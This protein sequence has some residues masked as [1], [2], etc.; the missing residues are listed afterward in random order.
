MQRLF[1]LG[2]RLLTGLVLLGP[3]TLAWADSG[4]GVD[5]WRGNKLDP[6]AG[7]AT[8][9]LDPDGTSWLEPG[10]HR[11]PTGNLYNEPPAEP[12]VET[13]SV[14]QIYGTF[15]VGYLHTTGER[16]ALFDRYSRWP[17]NG[18]SFGFDVKPSEL[19]TAA[20]PNCAAASSAPKTSTT[21]P[22]TARRA[23]TRRRSSF[24]TCRTCCPPTPSPFST[25]SAAMI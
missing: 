20:T 16:T 14:W 12:P 6:T 15:D 25:A 22:F 7:Q 4:V 23:P 24:A 9:P 21:K 2:T 17:A 1:G 3:A 5:T 10:Q 8:L 13:L 19:R 18:E 11:S